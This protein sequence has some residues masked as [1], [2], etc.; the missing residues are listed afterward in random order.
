MT[1]LLPF[2]HAIECGFTKHHSPNVNHHVLR[3]AT[4]R[5]EAYGLKG[6]FTKGRFFKI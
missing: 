1:H 3:G 6:V 4:V 5:K 2:F